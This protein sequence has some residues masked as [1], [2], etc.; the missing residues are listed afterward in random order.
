VIVRILTEG[1]FELDDSAL[2]KLNELDNAVV[3]AVEAG[4]EAKFTELFAQLVAM[5][6]E[7]GAEV[8]D[9]DLRPSQVILPPSDITMQEASEDFSGEGLIPG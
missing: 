1:Q 6:R 5:V 8:A 2:D 3:E 4:D 9:D 7:Q